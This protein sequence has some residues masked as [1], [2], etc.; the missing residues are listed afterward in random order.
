MDWKDSMNKVLDYIEDNITSDIDYCELA[1]IMSCSDYEFRRMFSCISQIPLSEYI[2]RRRLTMAAAD[3]RNGEKVIDVAI[4]YKYES[5][6]AFSRA[7]TKFHGVTPSLARNKD[8]KLNSYPRLY[9]KLVLMEDI[10]MKKK[11][12]QRTN[13]I[14]SGEVSYAVSI[15]RDEDSIQQ[16]NRVFWDTKGNDIMAAISL[17]MYGAFVSEENH[18][19]FGDVSGKKLLEIGCGRGQSLKYHAEHKADE[20]WGIDI[21][22]KQIEN[23]NVNL[24]ESGIKAKLICASMEEESGIPKDYFDYVYSVYGIGWT[25]DLVGTFKRIASYLKKDGVFIFS[26]SHPIHKCVASEYDSLTFKKCYFD[27]AWYSVPLECGTISLSD[28][29]MSTYINALTKAGFIIDEMIEESDEN[30]LSKYKDS[31]F[32]KK[33]QMLPVTFVIKA[34]K[35]N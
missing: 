10:A 27:E 28:R 30:I 26:W 33:A 3:I 17:P 24:N 20:L 22:G 23:A 32:A 29:K 21:S 7:F 14:G 8:I 12:N 19:L 4:K 18:H 5:Q 16:S 13:I 2:R 1:K 11:P 31:Q 35:L 9:F 25:T 15:N 6:S 34:R